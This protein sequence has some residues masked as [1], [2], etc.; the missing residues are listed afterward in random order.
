MD[1]VLTP[2]VTTVPTDMELTHMPTLDI[3]TLERDL[4]MPNQNQNHGTDMGVTDMVDMV[5]TDMVDIA[6]TTDVVMVTTVANAMLILN[7]KPHPNQ[8][9]GTDMGVTDMVAIMDVLMD[10]AEG[11]VATIMDNYR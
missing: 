3:T 2:T 7:L 6:V 9:H 4:L 5:V 11:I 10:I 8:I 1:M